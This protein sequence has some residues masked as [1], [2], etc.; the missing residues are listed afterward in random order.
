[1]RFL[2]LPLVLLLAACSPV[3]LAVGTGA[4]GVNAARQ[5]RGFTTA[6]SDTRIRVAIN[7]LW[8]RE[9]VDMFAGAGATVHEGR[10]LLTGA[11]RSDAQRR[12]AREL[13]GMVSRVEVIIDEM[14]VLPGY[15][16]SMRLTDERIVADLRSKLL[17]DGDVRSS[18][19]ALDSVDRTVYL[20][21]IAHNHAELARVQTHAA[22]ISG[23]R[24]IVSHVM[25]RDDP[26][27]RRRE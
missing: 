10:V 21:G 8:L 2:V 3:G 13:A 25:L 15:D 17:F 24:D 11:M 14:Q 7:E 12:R 18:N 6:I 27:R 4:A 23:V 5:E 20:F 26:R 19:Y 22:S 1:M 16:A 9:G